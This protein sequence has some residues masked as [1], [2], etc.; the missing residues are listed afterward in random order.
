MK[1]T[2]RTEVSPV[3]TN[4]TRIEVCDDFE[5]KGYTKEPRSSCR[6]VVISH[7]DGSQCVVCT[8]HK[9][10]IGLAPSNG[11]NE[12][13]AS[14]IQNHQVSPDATFILRHPTG[15]GIDVTQETV[16]IAKFTEGLPIYTRTD[17][18]VIANNLMIPVAILK[19]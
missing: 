17:W 14:L 19:L 10:Y 5:F 6:V 12:V 11:L 13:R 15:T 9:D 1:N 16:E 8:H 3:P 2:F 4:V 18:E 7:Y